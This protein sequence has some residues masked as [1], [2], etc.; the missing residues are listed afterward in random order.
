MSEAAK[1]FTIRL[2]KPGGKLGRTRKVVIA[3]ERLRPPHGQPV[4]IGDHFWSAGQ[5]WQV[6]KIEDTEILARIT[7]PAT[8][9]GRV[10]S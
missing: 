6:T 9:R 3:A 1:R 5:N 10:I 2:V 4:A 7:F 8:H